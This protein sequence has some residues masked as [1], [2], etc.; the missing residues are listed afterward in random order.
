MGSRAVVVRESEREW[1]G[2]PEDQRSQRG[3]VRWKTLVSSD[4][5]A[6]DS[7]TLGI[8]RLGPG[9]RLR[10]HRHPQAEAYV[11]L[12]GEL[13]LSVAGAEHRVEVGACAW[14]PG[15]TVHSCAN[16]GT[17]ETRFAYAFAADSEAEIAYDFGRE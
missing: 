8:A 2:W 17:V 11:V 10:E 16:D 12:S 4:L 6:S 15:G 3:E 1:Q 14:V 13:C 9:E 7:L 5:T